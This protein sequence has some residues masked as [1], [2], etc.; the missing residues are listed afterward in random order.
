ML[1]ITLESLVRRVE[2]LEKKVADEKDWR[3]VVGIFDDDSE[4]MQAVLTDVAA[5]REA[6]RKAAREEIAE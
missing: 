4:F 5:V 6:E 2:A 3:T 1:D